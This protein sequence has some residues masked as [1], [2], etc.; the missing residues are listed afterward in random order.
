MS[1]RQI[2]MKQMPSS[3]IVCSSLPLTNL[4]SPP[5]DCKELKGLCL[6]LQI[7]AWARDLAAEAN[8]DPQRHHGRPASAGTRLPALQLASLRSARHLPP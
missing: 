7:P 5:A 6:D 2:D 4:Q 8:G 3:H 1:M